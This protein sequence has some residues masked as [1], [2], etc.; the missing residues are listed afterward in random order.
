MWQYNYLQH[1]GTLGMKWGVRRYQNKNGSLTNAG[2][3]R[4]AIASPTKTYKTIKS[5]SKKLSTS[6]RDTLMFG[7]KGAERIANRQE[8]GKS[9]KYAVNIERAQQITKGLLATAAL[10]TTANLIASGKGA[11][12]ISKG[13]KAVKNMWDS[14]FDSMVIDAS[15]KVLNRYRGSVKEIV[16]DLAIK[17]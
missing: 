6:A 2:R 3:R 14:Q 12:L 11:E 4:N 7:P 13:S 16:T 15:G 9:R 10:A 17:R 5:Q 8:R 1:H